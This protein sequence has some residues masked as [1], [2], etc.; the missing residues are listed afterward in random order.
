MEDLFSFSLKTK[1]TLSTINIRRKTEYEHFKFTHLKCVKNTISSLISSEL[2][3][4]D[5]CK[6][7]SHDA[8][9]VSLLSQ[10]SQ[11]TCWPRELTEIWTVPVVSVADALINRRTSLAVLGTYHWKLLILFNLAFYLK[12]KYIK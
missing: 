12:C 3:P 1:Q 4:Y 8:S 5:L 10:I 2:L 6:K 11:S 9:V 7:K